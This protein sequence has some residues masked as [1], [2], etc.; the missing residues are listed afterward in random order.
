MGEYIFSLFLSCISGEWENGFTE[1]YP[2][3]KRGALD[4]GLF[5]VQIHDPDPLYDMYD[6]LIV[7][8]GS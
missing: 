2:Q 8:S 6:E 1:Q 4:H 5:I 7:G 3:M